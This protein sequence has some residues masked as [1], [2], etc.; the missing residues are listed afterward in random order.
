MPIISHIIKNLKMGTKR[1]SE[2]SNFYKA[3]AE[4]IRHI[5]NK[6]Q[7]EQDICIEELKNALYDQEED[8]KVQLDEV[9]SVNDDIIVMLTMQ[10]QE[11]KEKVLTLQSEIDAAVSSPQLPPS[12]TPA[13][14]A[15]SLNGK[16]V[17][18]NAE[19]GHGVVS[20]WRFGGYGRYT[21][22]SG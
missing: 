11:E 5:K 8:H 7:Q 18:T 9:N 13:I 12:H 14:H 21:A 16:V 2:S 22:V 10:L 15:L 3:K 17:H 4:N 19:E 6:E 1:L 20:Q